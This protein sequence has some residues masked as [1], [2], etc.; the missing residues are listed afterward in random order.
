[1]DKIGE[2]VHFYGDIKVA[3]L[4]LDESLSIGDT[5]TFRRAGEDL[6]EQKIASMEVD[7]VSVEAVSAGDEVAVKVSEQAK[8]GTEVYR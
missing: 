8:A 7:E 6:F 5:V 3:V 1:M 2:V 4:A